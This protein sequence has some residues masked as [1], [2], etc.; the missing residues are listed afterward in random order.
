MRTSA[1]RTCGSPQN[2][3]HTWGSVSAAVTI[4]EMEEGPPLQ[5][6]GLWQAHSPPLEG[7]YRSGPATTENPSVS[8]VELREVFVR[9]VTAPWRTSEPS[10][11][12]SSLSQ[13]PRERDAGCQVTYLCFKTLS[14]PQPAW[15]T[16]PPYMRSTHR[17]PERPHGHEAYL[18]SLNVLIRWGCG[19][20]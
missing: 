4:L 8:N 1:P 18:K 16:P 10:S 14:P 20:G 3:Q 15:Q 13:K 9:P 12:S 19:V 2:G 6:Q 17:R 5:R 11:H 7:R